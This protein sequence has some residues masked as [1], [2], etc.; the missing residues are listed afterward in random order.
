MYDCALDGPFGTCIFYV[1]TADIT[2][3]TFVYNGVSIDL[4]AV[5]VGA[6]G[7]VCGDGV[8]DLGETCNDG[9]NLPGDGCDAACQL[10]LVAP[11]PG[12][13]DFAALVAAI[14]LASARGLM[15]RGGRRRRSQR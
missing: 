5:A 3:E 10:E 11:V 1:N 9:N 6:G 7:P 14:S 2:I 15:A 12:L 8:V 4:S 13:G